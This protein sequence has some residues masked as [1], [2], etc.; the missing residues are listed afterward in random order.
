MEA[1][2]RRGLLALLALALLV[3]LAHLGVVEGEPFVADL[4]MD[5]AEY[6]RWARQ[7]A[8]G[9]W[10]GEEAFF[11][12]PLYPYLVAAVYALAGPSPAVIYVLQ[13]FAAAL[14]LGAL[15]WAGR[16]LGGAERGPALGLA[17]A[18]LGALYGPFLFYD[19][20]LLKES[21]AVTLVCGLLALL[22]RP[23]ERPRPRVWLT[24]GVVLGF[25][26]LLRENALLTGPFLLPLAAVAAPVGR[27]LRAVVLAAVLLGTGVALPL[28]PVALRNAWIGG[29]FLP[30]TYQGGVNFYIGNNPQADG[31]YRPLSPGKQVPALERREPVRL[32]E[33]ALGRPLEPAEVSR[34][35]L[36]RSLSWARDEPGAF[37]ALQ[38]R[39]LRRYWS[40]YEWPDA[41]DYYWMKE[42]SWPLR[43]PLLELGGAVLL[44][45]LGVLLER[46]RLR[47]WLPVLLWIAA[48]TASTVVFFVFSRYRLPMVPA[49]LLLGAVPVAEAG[50]GLV[51]WWGGVERARRPVLLV[52]AVSACW[53][54]P[55]GLPYRPRWDLVH[56]NLG[57]LHQE[58]GREE[59]AERHYREAVALDPQGFLAPL[60][61]GTLAARRGDLAAA[62]RWFELAVERQPASGDAHANLGG[63]ALALGDR[64]AAR[65]HLDRALELEPQHPAALQGRALLA[66]VEGDLTTA[67][68]LNGALL[69]ARPDHPQG[70]RL[71]ERLE[72]AATPPPAP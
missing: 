43:L 45:A 48:W 11:Q 42:R 49:L 12:A 50:A 13:I 60:N 30:T 14:G 17:A 64:P 52:L 56:F 38:L 39:K 26:V 24:A 46:R 31:T 67:W 58:A 4:A 7:I 63:A 2:F 40:F 25:L 28:A 3:R 47:V 9:D 34:Y 29:G 69:A 61:L 15:A 51:R 59:Q 16:R 19:V 62:R 32:A 8:G 57:R 21:L 18:F 23:P 10:V 5:S 27:R 35:W 44:A 36:G 20:Q 54:L 71:R 22:A 55:R 68:R 65:R 41:V 53:L 6:D 66:F 37:L 70:L 1:A 33:Q 72:A